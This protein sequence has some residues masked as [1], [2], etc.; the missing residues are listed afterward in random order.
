MTA[1]PG[2]LDGLLG[3]TFPGDNLAGLSVQ[4]GTTTGGGAS[5][6]ALVSL[7]ATT[8]GTPFQGGDPT[9]KVVGFNDTDS[10]LS[11]A[12]YDSLG[13]YIAT[14][15]YNVVG[16]AANALLVSTVFNQQEIATE[17]ALGM[18]S[19][20]NGT[21]A[22]LTTSV[23]PGNTNLTF[24]ATGM[25]T[26]APCFAAGA[27]IQTDSGAVA[28]EALR[29]GARVRCSRS[30]AFAPVRWIGR[31]RVDVARHPRPWDVAPVRIR[32]GA[33]A[34]GQPVRDLLLSPDHALLVGDALVPVRYLLNGGTIVQEFIA[35]IVYFHVE[36][37]AHDVLLAEGLAAESYLDTGNRGAF[38]NAPGAV[39]LTPDFARR[40]WAKRA[41][42]PLRTEGAPVQSE[43]ARLIARAETLGWQ[44][45][46]DPALAIFADGVPVAGTMR[47]DGI[48]VMLPPGTRGL[49][50]RSRA[51]RPAETRGEGGD[52]RRLGVGLA[53]LQLD[54]APIAEARFAAGW[55]AAERDLR[56]TDGDA[57]LGAEGARELTFALA[58][59]ETYWLAP[60]ATGGRRAS[61]AGK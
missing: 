61:T 50:L 17:L 42:A 54:R 57:L 27:R 13:D 6:Y 56:W 35:S 1:S 48:R 60:P 59:T 25:F 33:F 20:L 7:N 12:T 16:Y 28:V 15:T 23:L 4:S 31:R 58:R 38:G 44:R 5:P 29:P 9:F 18:A 43:R 8:T 41:C 53:T 34:P 10:S 32:A 30:G 39:D 26:G 51:A 37:E 36:L 47:G 19:G 46:P 24:G 52:G 14:L 3:Y 49:R 11:I 40:V 55:H 21:T 45:T 22:A 2:N